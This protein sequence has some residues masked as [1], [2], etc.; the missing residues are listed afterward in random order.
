MGTSRDG[1]VVLFVALFFGFAWFWWGLMPQTSA[2]DGSWILAYIA[3]PA[4]VVV[5]LIALAIAAIINVFRPEKRI[6]LSRTF[7]IT[8]VSLNLWAV[9]MWITVVNR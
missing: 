5:S 9:F 6:S 3:W 4:I 8:F 1:L 7:F 2:V